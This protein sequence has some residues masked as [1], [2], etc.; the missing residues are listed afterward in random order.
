LHCAPHPGGRRPRPFGGR[1]AAEHGPVGEHEGQRFPWPRRGENRR[2]R[3]ARFTG[4]ST[5][6]SV[7]R[8]RPRCRQVKSTTGARPGRARAYDDRAACLLR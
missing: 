4:V 8:V 3:D 6:E 5:P 1:C 2:R 7:K